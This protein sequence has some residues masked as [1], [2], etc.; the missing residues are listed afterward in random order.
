MASSA[1]CE[2]GA[3][4]T[5]D[6]VVLHCPIH[7]PPTDYTAWRSWTMRQP[8]GCSTPAPIPRRAS[9]GLKKN[10]F[11]RKK[12]NDSF[13]RSQFRVNYF[14]DQGMRGDVQVAAQ[15]LGR[16]AMHDWC[17]SLHALN[18][19]RYPTTEHY[20]LSYR[21]VQSSKAAVAKVSETAM[22]GRWVS[23]VCGPLSQF[24]INASETR[25]R[26]GDTTESDRDCFAR[27]SISRQ[28][29]IFSP[30]NRKQKLIGEMM[31]TTEAW[32]RQIQRECAEHIATST[33]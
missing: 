1:A 13:A 16:V 18:M 22:R 8:N 10:S 7:R 9:S 26:K 19:Q 4:Q 5:V 21:W 27:K 17:E 2:C 6:Y 3:E 11:E 24:D 31:K 33:R 23:K 28:W 15:G 30:A 29:R 12:K 14:F 20:S 32:R 25:H